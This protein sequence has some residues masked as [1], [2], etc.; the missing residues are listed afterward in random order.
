MIDLNQKPSEIAHIGN[1]SPLRLP[2]ACTATGAA[3]AILLPGE[4]LTHLGFQRRRKSYRLS[5]FVRQLRH[6]FG[7]PVSMT[8]IEN[9]IDPRKWHGEYLLE[10]AWRRAVIAAEPERIQ[11]FIDR[12][13]LLDDGLTDLGSDTKLAEIS[14]RSHD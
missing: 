11:N 13:K 4:K 2:D 9:P 1:F 3:A 10:D 7:F 5:E 12:A 8:R 6:D 14:R